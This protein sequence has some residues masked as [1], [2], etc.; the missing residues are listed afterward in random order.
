ML[1]QLIIQIALEQFL[2]GTFRSED[3]RLR[4][5]VYRTEYAHKVWR[6]TF[7]EVRVLRTENSYSY[8]KVLLLVIMVTMFA[9]LYHRITETLSTDASCNFD[10]W[11]CGWENGPGSFT[12]TRKFGPTQ[13]LDTG[14]S[15]D[16]TSGSGKSNAF[17]AT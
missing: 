9:E 5:R 3:G 10:I 15:R 8:L 12:W 14:P 2:L 4:I 1:V 13:S 6:P 16:H 11:Y 17:G 7:F